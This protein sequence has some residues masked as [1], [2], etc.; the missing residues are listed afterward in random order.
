M[1]LR[2]F[3]IGIAVLGVASCAPR[4]EP[5]SLA[6]DPQPIALEDF[7]IATE[8]LPTV[9]TSPSLPLQGAVYADYD[10]ESGI[11]H[12]Y[13]V[14]FGPLREVEAGV[15]GSVTA[16]SDLDP[17]Q[18]QVVTISTSTEEIQRNLMRVQVSV[19]QTVTPE[20]VIG[21]RFAVAHVT[22]SITSPDGEKV[23]PRTVYGAQYLD[24]PLIY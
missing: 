23:D 10:E 15:D 19:G 6:E 21:L 22:N 13:S 20:M 12:I 24:M 11:L 8:E 2:L 7:P 9:Q 3:A 4:P 1:T 5:E 14:G 16:V 17:R 18:F